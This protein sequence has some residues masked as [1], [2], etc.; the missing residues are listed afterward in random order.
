MELSAKKL[1]L[2][3]KLLSVSNASLLSRIS[4]LIDKENIV[5]YSASG[6]ALTLEDYNKRLEVAEK[7]LESGDYL[8]QEELEKKLEGC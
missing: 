2:M 4:D 5:G 1:E 6:E 7:Q 3:Q 8:T